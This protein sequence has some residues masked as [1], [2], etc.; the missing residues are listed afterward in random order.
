MTSTLLQS[1]EAVLRVKRLR[2][3]FARSSHSREILKREIQVLRNQIEEAV[4]N[5]TA[6]TGGR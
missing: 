1:L 6:L 3:S 4:R 2:L 5:P